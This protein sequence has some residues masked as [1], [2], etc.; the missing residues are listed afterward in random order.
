MI[1][2]QQSDP[3]NCDPPNS[4]RHRGSLCLAARLLHT[5]LH[6]T[7][8]QTSLMRCVSLC[9][10]GSN[11]FGKKKKIY[12]YI[13]GYL[14]LSFLV[15]FSC[16][17]LSLT[18]SHHPEMVHPALQSILVSPQVKSCSSHGRDLC[19]FS[20]YPPSIN[21]EGNKTLE[22]GKELTRVRR[23]TTKR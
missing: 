12:I 16:S 2:W 17:T 14:C 10:N 19:F 1:Q 11:T 18:W 4:Y 7:E 20:C 9:S 15:I 21:P 13:F 6:P 23:N 8:Q 3:P 22:R 5:E